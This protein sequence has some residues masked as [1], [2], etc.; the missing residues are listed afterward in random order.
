MQNLKAFGRIWDNLGVTSLRFEIS[1]IWE[2]L[3]NMS[4]GI[5]LLDHWV[6]EVCY[7]VLKNIG[8]FHKKF[9]KVSH[10]LEQDKKD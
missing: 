10:C 6:F 3:N 1:Q 9:G 7:D 2:D 5:Y 4:K 8:S